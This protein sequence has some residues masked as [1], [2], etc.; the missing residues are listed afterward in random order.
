M[1]YNPRKKS[2]SFWGKK[3][4]TYRLGIY[5]QLTRGDH[6]AL[7]LG[8]SPIFCASLG[9]PRTTQDLVEK[10]SSCGGCMSKAHRV[11]GHFIDLQKALKKFYQ[12]PHILYPV[13]SRLVLRSQALPM[14]LS[15][16]WPYEC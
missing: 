1:E 9:E 11:S 13:T 5:R 8:D 3:N 15:F 7:I 16:V 6:I 2:L 14:I 4:L 10:A 12:C